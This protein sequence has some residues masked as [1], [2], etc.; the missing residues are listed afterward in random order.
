MELALSLV[1]GASVL[2]FGVCLSMSFIA[3]PFSRRNVLL[4]LCFC[5]ASGFVQA[6]LLAHSTELPTKLYPLVSH[7]PLIVYLCALCGQRPL[8]VAVAVFTA[9]F[10][11][12]PANW[13]GILT[14]QLSSSAVLEHA[15][16]VAA[17]AA[18]AAVVLKFLSSSVADVLRM[19]RRTVLCF[20]IVPTT[21][22]FF[23]YITS[24]YT[25]VWASN[26]RAVIEFLPMF[27]LVSYFVF[28]VAYNNARSAEEQR[29]KR[30]NIVL[31]S[32]RQKEKE[33]ET[34]LLAENRLRML[35][36]DMRSF[37]ENLAVSIEN[38]DRENS[39]KMLRGYLDQVDSTAL[40]H[41]CESEIINYT[42]SR[43]ADKCSAR[44]ISFEAEVAC[45]GREVDEVLLSSIISNT[46]DNAINA[47]QGLGEDKRHILL[48]LKARDKRLLFSVRNSFGRAPRFVDGMPV[49]RRD[50]HGYGS[51]SIRYT[52]E[53]LGGRCQFLVQDGM[54]VTRVIL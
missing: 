23:D 2:L 18:T 5:L 15:V 13:L 35:R 43:Y 31:L 7:L 36:H 10:C 46:M 27:L 33:A 50:G 40:K 37:L 28:C 9:Y 30:E 34:I 21:Y 8:S 25:N 16:R 45:T 48:M 53:H 32:A 38:D 6:L 4:G 29:R 26:N 12:Q 1:Y 24:V 39:L 11:C 14:F 20:A 41:Y 49:S 47:Q 42:L 52:A 51:Q 54:F 3:L 44:G 22:Y 17:L 19:N